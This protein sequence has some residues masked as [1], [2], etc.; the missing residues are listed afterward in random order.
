MSFANLPVSFKYTGDVNSEI[1]RVPLY[2]QCKRLTSIKQTRARLSKAAKQLNSDFKKHKGK[3]PLGFIAV[4][5][6]K[7]NNPEGITMVA[8][9]T[10]EVE[11]QNSNFRHAFID[12]NIQDLSLIH[13]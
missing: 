4:D 9:T 1:D 11:E 3:M 8:E 10:R 5:I 6:T 12:S 2:F 13:I 7:L